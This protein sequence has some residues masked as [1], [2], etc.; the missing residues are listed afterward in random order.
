MSGEEVAYI[1][2]LRANILSFLDDASRRGVMFVSKSF[3]ETCMALAT[4]AAGVRDVR[5]VLL[6]HLARPRDAFFPVSTE[7]F[8]RLAVER[9]FPVCALAKKMIEDARRCASFGDARA[10]GKVALLAATAAVG[11]SSVHGL[12]HGLVH[13]YE[14][15]EAV[16]AI[17]DNAGGTL[18]VLPGDKTRPARIMSAPEFS[19]CLVPLAT[20]F[21]RDCQRGMLS[22]RR[23]AIP[24]PWN[25]YPMEDDEIVRTVTARAHWDRALARIEIA[26]KISG[27]PDILG[28]LVHL[29]S[30]CNKERIVLDFGATGKCFRAVPR[31]LLTPPGKF[32]ARRTIVLRGANFTRF[33][34][35]GLHAL[36]ESLAGERPH[37]RLCIEDGDAKAR[38]RAI[39]WKDFDRPEFI[40]IFPCLV[41]T[42]R[43]GAADLLPTLHARDRMHAPGVVSPR[44][45]VVIERVLCARSVRRVREERPEDTAEDVARVLRDMPPLAR[46]ECTES[47]QW[48]VQ[49]AALGREPRKVKII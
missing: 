43:C 7:T 6:A 8:A 1:S 42:V 29:M 21:L 16:R 10:L 31:P 25:L 24:F 28:A 34:S 12:G 14:M 5:S 40:Q 15:S 22:R 26:G 46:L 2:P 13:P 3:F 38:P 32:A 47:S 44:P 20:A 27:S 49:T 41:W 48:L 17:A 19:R 4:S 35:G 11:M 23:R 18:T 39:S 45:A 9:A 33:V 37:H 30:S 36:E